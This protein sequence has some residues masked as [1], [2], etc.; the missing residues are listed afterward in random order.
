MRMRA[1]VLDQMQMPQPYAKTKPISVEAVELDAPGPGEVLVK[2]AA[3]GLCHSDLSII[4]GDRPRVMPLALGHE[5]SAVVEET[6]P[7]IADLKRGDHVAL[8]FVP[9]CGH[10]LPCME[11]RPALCEP[12]AAAAVAGTLVS[13]QRRLHRADRSPINHQVGVSCFAEYAVVARGTL[14]KIDP[15][16][17]LDIAALFGCAVL[18]GVGAAINAGQLRLG[19][20]AAVVGLGGVG[21]SALLGAMAAGARQIVAID[22]LDAKLEFARALGATHTFRADDP[23]LVARVKAVTH[24][25]VEVAIEAASAVAALDTAYKITRRGGTT[26]TVSLPPPQATL[27]VPAVNLVVEERTLKGSYL[28]SAVPAR[29]IPRYIALYR[30]GRLPIDKL[31]THRIKLDDINLGFDRLANGEAIRQVIVF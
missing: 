10:C 11:G 31:V 20:S 1:A 8:I 30:A 15:E 17:P 4:N 22:K 29:D 12:G 7:G 18:T 2:M 25:G 19:S 9:S 16:L 5:A 23:D 28:G 14:V 27:N 6:G 26:V 3:A 13:G 24:G 21:L